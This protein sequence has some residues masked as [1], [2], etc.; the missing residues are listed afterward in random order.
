MFS[1]ETAKAKE[2]AP[3]PAPATCPAVTTKGDLVT[4]SMAV[5]TG[6]RATSCLLLERTA[7][8]EVTLGKA[9][10]YT[11]DVI[12]LTNCP[13]DDVVITDR[14][15][16]GGFEFQSSTPEATLLPD[17]TGQRNLGTNPAKGS[18]QIRVQG[19]ANQA[20]DI[21]QCLR[22][23]YVR[24]LCQT[25]KVS[26]PALKLAKTMPSEVT[27][28][29]EIPVR[30]VVSNPGTGALRDVTVTDTL[31]AGLTTA[32][33]KGIATFDIGPLK[34]GESREVSYVA[35][36]QDTGTFENAA[37]A[38]SA[39]GLTAD[40]KAS[41]TVRQAVLTLDKTGP[42]TL[43]AGRDAQYGIKVANTGDTVAKGVVL[44]DVIPAG[45]TFVSAS[46]G[47][48]ATADTVT[49]NLG[50]IAA[51]DSR[52]VTLTVRCESIGETTNKAMAEAACAKPV[53]DLVVTSIKGIPA[54][55]LEVLD[56]TDPVEVGNEETYIITVTNQGS[57]A[58]SNIAITCILEDAQA[59]VSGSGATVATQTGQV[60]K[61]APLPT[62][63][64]KAKA[65]WKVVVKAL[66][67]G[68]IRF[69]VE[70]N[71]DQLG[72]PVNETE[73]TNQY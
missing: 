67:A 33:G 29:D 20:G 16:G 21:S 50:D 56:V 9:Y 70:M 2:E 28:C 34:A 72:R 57:L 6:D 40:A 60:V 25:V 59:F 55:L 61:F 41:V 68:D 12:N 39:E 18:Q 24:N 19:V 43:F 48:S 14:L 62:L 26:E 38:K 27:L 3:A 64:P 23:S 15:T 22:A 54:V 45:T 11:I 17:G 69:S 47:G 66:T 58:D 5:P 36:A 7:P 44:K 37:S 35:K 71:T 73:A 8:A 49:W 53:E 42:A 13:L 4:S 32:D 1:P 30:L 46:G 10:E 52:D 31:P 63:A 51:G 65:E